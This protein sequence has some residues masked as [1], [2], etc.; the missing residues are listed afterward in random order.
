MN[1]T[2]TI[3]TAVKLSNIKPQSTCITSE[4]IH[5]DSFMYVKDPLKVTSQN[6]KRAIKKDKNKQEVLI[7]ADPQD[8]KCLPNNPARHEPIIDKKTINK[9]I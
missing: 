3:I 1:V 4:L 5:V 6:I 2:T 7:N 9:Y 8:P